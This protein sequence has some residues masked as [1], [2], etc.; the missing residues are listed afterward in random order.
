MRRRESQP[1]KKEAWTLS[2]PEASAP[3]RRSTIRQDEYTS[4]RHAPSEKKKWRYACRILGTDSLKDGEIWHGE[5]KMHLLLGYGTIKSDATMEHE[6]LRQR[7]NSYSRNNRRTVGSGV[8]CAVRLGGYMTK[9]YRSCKKM[10]FL[11][12]TSREL[13]HNHVNPNVRGIGQ[14]EARRRKYKGAHTRT[15]LAR[16][17]GSARVPIS[18][19]RLCVGRHEPGSPGPSVG[20]GSPPARY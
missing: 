2:K 16:E 11:L 5:W 6:T 18:Q 15:S 3:A 12:G 17:S 1:M 9:E 14:G 13:K 8:F 20:L 4:H 7:S 10:C 19:T